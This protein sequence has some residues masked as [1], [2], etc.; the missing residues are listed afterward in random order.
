MIRKLIK[1]KFKGKKINEISIKP[2]FL[3]FFD[4]VFENCLIS[5]KVMRNIAS[6]FY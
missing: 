1:M 5:K 2:N 6:E 4:S 3:E